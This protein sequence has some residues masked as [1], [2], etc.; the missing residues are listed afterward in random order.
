MTT[1]SLS[2][3]LNGRAFEPGETLRGMY[4]LVNADLSRLAEVEVTVGWH[5]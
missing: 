3:E 1:G 2:I 4:R 5:T